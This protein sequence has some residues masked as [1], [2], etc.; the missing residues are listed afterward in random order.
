[1]RRRVSLYIGDRL[2]DLS[3]ESFI[4][5][6]YTLEDVADP[7]VIQN[8]FS[9][10]ITLPGTAANNA[11]FGHAFRLDRVPQL[12]ETERTGRHF[13]PL[14]RTPFA[15]Y[16]D[17]GEI[18]E[19]GYLKLD[20]VERQAG[21]S[22]SYVCTLYGGLGSF[23][24]GLAYDAQGNKR[25][26][27]DLDF[28]Q[29]GSPETEFDFT[30]NATTVQTAWNMLQASP[31][32][33]KWSIINFAPCYNGY[34]DGDFDPAHGLFDP[35]RSNLPIA[36]GGASTTYTAGYALATLP[37]KFSEWEV[38]DLRSYLQRPVV[39]VSKV[40]RAIAD[41]VNNGGWTVSL[42]GIEDADLDWEDMWMTLPML[43]SLGGFKQTTGS[44]SASLVSS[45][46]TG[47][48]IGY[49]AISGTNT[50]PVGTQ[51]KAT[52][53]VRPVI[54]SDGYTAATLIQELGNAKYSAAFIQAVAVDAYSND[55]G[56]SQVFCLRGRDP[57]NGGR[58]VQAIA[59]SLGFSANYN[60]DNAWDG[61]VLNG[62]WD[63]AGGAYACRHSLPFQLTIA[64]GSALDRIEVRMWAYTYKATAFWMHSPTGGTDAKL[65]VVEYGSTTEKTATGAYF[66]AGSGTNSL[67]YTTPET[68]RSN[69][70]VTKRMLLSTD[71]TPADFL[72]SFCKTFGMVIVC[73]DAAKT[74][75][76]KKRDNFYGDPSNPIDLT[77][78][79]DT[80]SG[81]T[82]EPCGFSTRW[83][84][85]K[86]ASVGGA[87]EAEYQ[88]MQGRQYGIQ[89]V[90]TGYDFNAEVKDVLQGT[91]FRSAA[92]VLESS[93]CFYCFMGAGTLVYPTP[94]VYSGNKYT[95]WDASG[96][97]VDLDIPSIPASVVAAA[98]PVNQYGHEGYD[99]EWAWKVQL[100]AADGKPLDG[101]GVLLFYNGTDG[102]D[103]YH[104]T[105]DHAIMHTV[106]NGTPCWFLDYLPNY[107]LDVPCFSRYTPE[108]MD[109]DVLAALDFGRPAELDI[110][111]I[112]YPEDVT[113]Y[114]KRWGAYLGDRL[115][116]ATKVLRC[117]V[118]LKGLQVGQPLLGSFW[119]YDGCLW[120]LNKITNHS[121]TTWDLTECEF[122]QV[123]DPA[124]YTNGQ[125]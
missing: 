109:W 87:F 23:L 49:F 68:L 112:D 117:K 107:T 57:F 29:T 59:Q 94:F 91:V 88:Q 31:R 120:V 121:L 4:L 21:G 22:V 75:T 44:L 93:P 33:G 70:Q 19:S 103:G 30:I 125:N 46:A 10:Q 119:W 54:P 39:N 9:Q 65:H 18:L 24:Y 69:A 101:S 76:V 100:H 16:L 51:V 98:D 41:G 3:D 81:L 110:P 61:E 77:K 60:S 47:P 95:L 67:T 82:I 40:L 2:A 34:P 83:W 17:T 71:Y 1:M 118:D 7:A 104:L 124:N 26:L 55:I 64:D 66:V 73:D 36:S 85:F 80:A 25:S 53:N 62:L 116:A 114:A 42:P 108:N 45:A 27:A 8:A 84:D 35:S 105:D 12:S 89:R 13:A 123:Q 50:L 90:N 20:R 74:V 72:T 79:I 97:T 15:L 28:L 6:N 63:A 86:A 11:I 111:Y 32:S 37:R 106:N 115:D 102:Y 5:F 78:R 43:P 122:V 96:E 99:S 38:K 92:S 48:Q 56:G 113:L 14:L 58:A 52:L